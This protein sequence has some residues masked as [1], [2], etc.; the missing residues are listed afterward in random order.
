M[1]N[2]TQ[3]NDKHTKIKR[4]QKTEKLFFLFQM[5]KDTN[6]KTTE[7]GGGGGTKGSD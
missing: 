3:L 6:M 7:K 5:I 2:K 4:Q 1:L